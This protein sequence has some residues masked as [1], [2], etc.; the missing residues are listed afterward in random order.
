MSTVQ[1][2]EEANPRLTR[3][4]QETLR[5]CLGNYLEDPMELND[6]IAA[7]LDASRSEISAGRFTTRRPE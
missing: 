1:E 6:V 4:E 2:I 7:K 3:A 5:Q